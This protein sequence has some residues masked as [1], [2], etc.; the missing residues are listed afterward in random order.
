M[1][2]LRNELQVDLI[3][4]LP[5]DNTSDQAHFHRWV[6]QRTARTNLSGTQGHACF[7]INGNDG[8][9]RRSLKYDFASHSFGEGDQ[10]TAV[11]GRS[12]QRIKWNHSGI[13]SEIENHYKLRIDSDV[14]NSQIHAY[15]LSS[16]STPPSFLLF[17]STVFR[18]QL[19]YPSTQLSCGR[20]TFLCIALGLQ[21]ICAH[22]SSACLATCPAQRQFIFVIFSFH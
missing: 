17:S 3:Y 13:M 6:G 8:G 5:S 1:P 16:F 19:V 20:P 21:S 22:L 4:P 11:A 14:L 9:D 7:Y 12:S 18:P 10:E 15:S 2:S